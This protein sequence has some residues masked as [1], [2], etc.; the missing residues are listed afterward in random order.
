METKPEA[1]PEEDNEM[2]AEL[3]ATPEADSEMKAESSVATS[4]VPMEVVVPCQATPPSREGGVTVETKREGVSSYAPPGRLQQEKARLQSLG[5]VFH[6]LA[7]EERESISSQM[8]TVQHPLPPPPPP[9]IT[10]QWQVATMLPPPPP[11]P[12]SQPPSS[13]KRPRGGRYR[14]GYAAHYGVKAAPRKPPRH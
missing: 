3:E 13:N 6:P 7:G 11:P 14:E 5:H 9:Q 2:T 8:E 1:A 4:E 10:Q 12:T